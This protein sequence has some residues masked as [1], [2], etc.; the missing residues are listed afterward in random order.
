MIK[1]ENKSTTITQDSSKIHGNLLSDI[2][3]KILKHKIAKDK[4]NPY[5]NDNALYFKVSWA[6][7]EGFQE[8][9]P[10]YYRYEQLIPRCAEILLRYYHD[11]SVLYYNDLD[12]DIRVRK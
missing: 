6:K 3:V 8:I 11:N 12:E 1:R 9:L 2:P 5:R 7:R 4:D 10:T